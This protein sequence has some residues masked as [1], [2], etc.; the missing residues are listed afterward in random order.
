MT[1]T[2]GHNNPPF[3]PEELRAQFE[4]PLDEARNWLD[5]HKVENKDQ[6]EAVIN[7]STA[8]KAAEKAF[9]LEEKK[10]VTPLREAWK[11]EKDRWRPFI[12]ETANLKAGLLKLVSDF[13]AALR[14]E[15]E[16]EK[17]KALA[18]AKRKEEAARAAVEAA[19][20]SDIAQVEEAQ[21]ALQEAKEAKQ[22]ARETDTVKG[23]R[24]TYKYEID[25]LRGALNWIAQN[26][27]A[28]LGGYVRQY[29]AHNHKRL[30]KEGR[31]PTGVRIWTEKEAF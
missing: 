22:E 17:A 20:A 15:Q 14:A 4:A 10:R 30:H 25:D 1:A 19:D 8:V 27:K 2:I 3:G 29:I 26:D 9:T 23:L 5:G 24:T 13:K 12:D 6:M 31:I 21:R 18:E 7:L 16:R 28:S 11:N